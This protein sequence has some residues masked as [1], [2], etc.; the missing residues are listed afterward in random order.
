MGH[1]IIASRWAIVENRA[2]T[3]LVTLI[4]F[5]ARNLVK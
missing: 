4:A 2:K 3:D 5:S 1:A